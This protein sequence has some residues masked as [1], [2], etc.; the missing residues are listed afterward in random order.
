MKVPEKGPLIAALS[1]VRSIQIEYRRPRAGT[2]ARTYRTGIG[3]KFYWQPVSAVELHGFM[4]A[5]T[6]GGGELRA[7]GGGWPPGPRASGRRLTD[8]MMDDVQ[9]TTT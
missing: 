1:T 7:V 6:G 4:L 5:C 2:R 9:T 8:Y 3:V